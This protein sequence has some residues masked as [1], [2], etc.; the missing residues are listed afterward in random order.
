MNA[1]AIA[2]AVPQVTTDPGAIAKRDA[3]LGESAGVVA[4]RNAIDYEAAGGIVAELKAIARDVE[5]ARKDIKAPVLELG[6]RIDAAAAEFLRGVEG[7]VV[8]IG[9]M[10]VAYD[11]EQQRIRA[12]AERKARE[13][14]ERAERARREAEAAEAR[15]IAELKAAEERAKREAEEAIRRAKETQD[16][17]ARAEAEQKARDA[18]QASRQAEEAQRM[19][20]LAALTAAPAAPVAVAPPPPP[21]VAGLRLRQVQCHEVQDVVALYKARPDLV[22]LVPIAG[23]INAALEAGETLPGV[24]GWKEGRA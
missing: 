6:K 22:K 4:V 9:K 23:A 21:K 24:R 1:I 19:A 2:G 13:E 3:I 10:L 11:T 8:R 16:A 17:A 7:E 18:A 20:N 5:K 15:R 14:A 12:E